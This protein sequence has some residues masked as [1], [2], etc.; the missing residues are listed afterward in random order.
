MRPLKTCSQ[1]AV[2][3]RPLELKTYLQSGCR[4]ALYGRARARRA[5]RASVA[6]VWPAPPGGGA[7]RSPK[8]GKE[9]GAWASVRRRRRRCS[10]PNAAAK[11]KDTLAVR[12]RRP[13]RARMGKAEQGGA[14]TS[15]DNSGSLCGVWRPYVLC[16]GAGTGG[17]KSTRL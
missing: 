5:P 16:V 13:L 2:R 3:L 17:R 7:R 6:P 4:G 11:A 10:K 14:S 15:T 12:L 1:L 9:L 8:L